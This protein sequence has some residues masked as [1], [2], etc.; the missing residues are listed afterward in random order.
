MKFYNCCP[1]LFTPN[2]TSRTIC[3]DRISYRIII[4]VIWT[5]WTNYTAGIYGP[6]NFYGPYVPP[7]NFYGSYVSTVT[8]RTPFSKMGITLCTDVRLRPI[9]YRWKA[10][11]KGYN[12]HQGSFPKFQIPFE[13]RVVF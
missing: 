7:Y 11:S 3:T 4:P 6:Y 9:I 2:F 13:I 5:F 12:F 8:D 1:C 10:I